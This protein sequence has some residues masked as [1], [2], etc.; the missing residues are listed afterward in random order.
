MN[1]AVMGPVL[2]TVSRKRSAESGD[3]GR[4]DPAV[5]A[6]QIV[7]TPGLDALP[8]KFVEEGKDRGVQA[9]VE[10]GGKL[11]GD[12]GAEIP[13][14][15]FDG[16]L[17]AGEF[18]EKLGGAFAETFVLME[19]G[20]KALL[21]GEGLRGRNLAADPEQKSLSEADDFGVAVPLG[22]CEFSD[23]LVEGDGGDRFKERYGDSEV[24]SEEFHSLLKKTDP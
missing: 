4:C 3:D 10:D 6:G 2:S 5:G 9:V 1:Q 7:L 15:G 13:D 14:G 24:E 23:G 20:G 11:T 8:S 21:D 19:E 22:R 12:Q 16:D 17:G 18:I